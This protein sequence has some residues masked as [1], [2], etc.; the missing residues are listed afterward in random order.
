M[1]SEAALGPGVR[2]DGYGGFISVHAAAGNSTQQFYEEL[3][4]LL[5]LTRLPQL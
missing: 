5:C 2:D 1:L 4:R 3:W